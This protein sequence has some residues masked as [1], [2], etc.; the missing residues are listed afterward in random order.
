VL[1]HKTLNGSGI[2]AGGAYRITSD[3]PVIA[4]QFNPLDGAN[5]YLS[6]ASLLLPASAYDTYYIVPGYLYGPDIAGANWPVH[7]QI[8]AMAATQVWVTSTAATVAGTGV[9][10]LTPGVEQSFNLQEGDYLQLTLA[11]V[12]TSFAGT[13]IRSS[14]PVAVFSSADCSNVPYGSQNCCC[15]HLEEQIFGLQ[16]WGKQYV[17]ARVWKIANEPALWQIIAQQNGTTVTFSASPGVTGLP[18]GPVTLNARQSVEYLVNGSGGAVGDFFVSADKPILVTQ[19]TVGSFLG[20]GTN[21]D[22]DMVQAVPVEQFL[23]A[24][25]IL[26]PTTWVYDSVTL[27]R[28]AGATVKIDGNP[29]ASGW[30]SVALSGYEVTRTRVGDGVHV[31]EGTEPFG[32]IVN[33]YDAYDSYS[34]PGGLNQQVINPIN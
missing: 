19:F 6:D 13:Y 28:K 17:A 24:Y 11:Q 26:V 12:A 29:V 8:V 4:Y 9:P 33:G 23:S 10:A 5:S 18:A 34:Y 25:V 1:P 15:E 22:P 3:L 21:G 14:N 20:D 31:L 7:L 16:T 27:I 2:M 32:V 30:V